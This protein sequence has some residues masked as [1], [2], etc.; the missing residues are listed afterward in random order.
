MLHAAPVL[1][2]ER[3]GERRLDPERVASPLARADG[4]PAAGWRV[5]RALDEGQLALELAAGEGTS[6]ALCV[7]LTPPPPPG[8]RVD[9]EAGDQLV[10]S[11]PMDA[12]G[13]LSFLALKPGRYR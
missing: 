2:F 11:R 5:K 3:C 4:A 1:V 12:A 9:L 10:E 8:T 13:V 7:A 6:F